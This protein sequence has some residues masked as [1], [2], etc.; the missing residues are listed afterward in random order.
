MKKI[1]NMRKDME[2]PFKFFMYN[3]SRKIGKAF[4]IP[5][6]YTYSFTSICDSNCVTCNIWKKEVKDELSIN[7]W[8]KTL[9]SIGSAPYWVTITGG[10]QFLRKD[11]IEFFKLIVKYNKPKI[12]NIP[13]SA[14]NPDLVYKTSQELIK[15]IAKENIRLILNFS[16]DGIGDMHD[17]IRGK[18]NCFK[19]T[20]ETIDM[21][22]SL[23]LRYKNLYVGTYTIISKYNEDRFS[24]TLEFIKNKIKPDHLGFEIA[25]IR[26]EYRNNK[27]N[28]LPS[29][30][31]AK[32]IL[33]R[34]TLITGEGSSRMIKLKNRIRK[35]Y[36]SFVKKTLD[37][38]CEI[39]KCHAGIASIQISIN[40]SVWQCPTNSKKMGNLRKNGYDFKK[41]FFSEKANRIRNEIK[42]EKCFCTHSNPFYT[43]ILCSLK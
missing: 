30:D 16:L 42:E 12:I 41:I 17:K 18:K 29:S 38:Q 36:Y 32:D 37:K 7:E 27:N 20:L 5:I 26:D 33:R 4:I 21:V 6:N 10:N 9:Q 19:N 24:D 11:F 2:L 15:I 31:K 25:E 28:I 13:V 40:G 34:L 43:N 14:T 1:W 23:K 3:I 22:K 35:K 39:I 8:E